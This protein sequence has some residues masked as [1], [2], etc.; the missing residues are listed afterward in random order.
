VLE[1]RQDARRERWGAAALDQL[2]QS[3]QVHGALTRKL[4]G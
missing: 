4:L 2:D 3:V 1:R